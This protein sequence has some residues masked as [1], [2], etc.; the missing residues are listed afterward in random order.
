MV[1]LPESWVPLK[2]HPVQAS[3]WTTKKRFVAVPAGR[4]SGKTELARRRL[5]RMLPVIKPWKDPLYFYGGP[6]YGQA[7][8]IAWN[9]FLRLIPK[10]WVEKISASD[11][12]IKT[13]FGSELHVVGL[14]KPQRIEGSQW[15]GGVIDE[16]CDIKPKTFDLSILPALTWRNGWCWRIGV[17][18]RFGIGAAEFREFYEKACRGEIEDAAGFSW[19]SSDI[20]PQKALNYARSI[21]DERDFLEQFDASWQTTGG[22]VFYAF[23]E[24]ANIRPCSYDPNKT[25]LVGSDFNV[26]PMAWVLCHL[27]NDTLE[28]FDEIWLRNT[29]TITTCRVLAERYATHKGGWQFFGDASGK[30]RKTSASSS[31]ISQIAT[32]PQFLRQGRVIA[33][34]RSN[35]PIAD[36]FAAMNA[37]IKS[38]SGQRKVYIDPRC[39]HL[40]FDL[41]SR[42]YKPGTREVADVGDLG[43]IT[44]ALGYI[45]YKLFPIR[46]PVEGSEPY[47]VY[48]T[49]PVGEAVRGKLSQVLA[50]SANR[51][52]EKISKQSSIRR[53]KLQ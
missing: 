37:R 50:Q 35:P 29:N 7:K 9:A 12:I 23:D 40:K 13:I 15:D 32:F 25:I 46:V 27:K 52:K 45:I 48:V 39:K 22:G 14:D 1:E 34:M 53:E 33:Y 11:L 41:M 21:M 20:I 44:D 43:H 8:R 42:V 10:E 24:E 51:E 31:D 6:T 18:K 5:V 49:K 47:E 3:L 26:D 4:G 2:Y 38:S 19:P 36:R 16:S 28:V 30:A 17:P